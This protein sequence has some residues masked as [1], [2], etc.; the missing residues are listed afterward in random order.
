MVSTALLTEKERLQLDDTIRARRAALRRLSEVC[1][2]AFEDWMR[3]RELA[4]TLPNITYG[5]YMRDEFW[6]AFV[7]G[8]NARGAMRGESPCGS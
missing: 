8:W 6:S 7:A 2:L 3:D 5:P 4:G 1:K